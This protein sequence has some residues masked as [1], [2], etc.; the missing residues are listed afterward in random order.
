[1][2]HNNY[3]VQTFVLFQCTAHETAALVSKL[4]DMFWVHSKVMAISY[5]HLFQGW[6]IEHDLQMDLISVA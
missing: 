3:S 2:N 5:Q 6:A 1:M 4:L